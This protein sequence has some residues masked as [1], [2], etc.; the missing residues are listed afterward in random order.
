METVST[1]GRA[2]APVHGGPQGAAPTAERFAVAPPSTAQD[3]RAGESP[4]QTPPPIAAS[5]VVRTPSQ[6][7][8]R[9]TSVQTIAGSEGVQQVDAASDVGAA[10]APQSAPPTPQTP[11]ADQ[12][13]EAIS[14]GGVRAGRRV[15]VRLHP[16]ELG[17]VRV[18]IRSDGD[19]VRGV[20]EVDNAR[21]LAEVERQSAA[22][23][24]RLSD[25]GIAF[26]RLDVTLNDASQRGGA[27]SDGHSA[28]RDG[29]QAA[30]GNDGDNRGGALQ[31]GRS[32]SQPNGGPDS[33]DP[34]E[35]AA[36]GG[37]RAHVADNSI[38]VWL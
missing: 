16:P 35:N 24:E 9:V 7:S 29:D 1:D 5:A 23:A 13:A 26:R 22:L 12:I 25:Q 36:V 20:V 4:I 33:H 10:R 2:D 19:G 28:T 32:E 15:V 27:D 21:T 34:A 11:V 18:T 38:N 37:G 31:A 14:G 6:P 3:A 8:T 17:S 30:A